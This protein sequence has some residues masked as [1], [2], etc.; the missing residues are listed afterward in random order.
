[1]GAATEDH[2][3]GSPAS[4][5]LGCAHGAS[6]LEDLLKATDAAHYEAKAAGRNCGRQAG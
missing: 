3:R 5:S 2:G 4:T 1:M 6:N